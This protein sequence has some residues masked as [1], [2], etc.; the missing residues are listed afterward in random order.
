MFALGRLFRGLV[1]HGRLRVTDFDGQIYEF[2]NNAVP[3]D[4]TI[5]LRDPGTAW[6]IARNPE[7]NIGETYLDGSLII[8][9]GTLS[10][11]LRLLLINSQ[12]WNDSFTGRIYYRLDDIFRTPAVLNPVPRA[13]RNVKHHYDLSDKLFSLFLDAD[14]QYS[15]AYYRSEDDDLETAQ[16][17]KKQHIASKLNIHP[18]QHVLDIGS[19]WG[20]LALYIARHYPVRVTGLT[21]SDEQ[22]R[23]ANERARQL[24]MGDR[25][26]F[27]LLDYRKETGVYDRIVSVGMFEHVGRP[28][29]SA[30]FRQLSALLKPDGVALI[31]TIGTQAR[32]SPINPWLRRHIFPGAYLPALSQIAPIIEA[33]RMW[34]TDLENLRLHYAST[35]AAWRERFDANRDRIALLYDERFCRMWEF[36]LQSCEAGFRWSGL[37]VF[38]LQLTK[39]IDALPVTRD[40]MLR[41][42]DRLR[43]AD[44]MM[45]SNQHSV[46]VASAPQSSAER[47]SA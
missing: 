33:R 6:R 42:E 47:R 23:H 45:N 43:M 29:F 12:S 28:H 7:L 32:P 46:L 37:T 30:F 13:R 16:L 2:G 26:T 44:A 1:K 11:F 3:L 18:G 22:F 38:Q 27:K 20:G 5:A 35:L 40:Y 39:S 25:V 24:G 41:E 4:A 36:Y 31:H 21:L 8:E 15:C 9:K 19:G 10:S 17:A 34:L 14:R